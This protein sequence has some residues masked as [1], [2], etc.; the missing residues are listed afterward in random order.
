MNQQLQR[1]IQ[2]LNER[3][4]LLAREAFQRDPEHAALIFGLPTSVGER[5]A[6][7]SQED[8]S[9]IAAGELVLLRSRQPPQW[10]EM[11]C[12]A[13]EKGDAHAINILHS[14]AIACLPAEP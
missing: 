5:L 7:L 14:Q 9:S 3:W 11:V 10:W 4:L 2:R 13:L 12:A 1:D 8:L 6:Q